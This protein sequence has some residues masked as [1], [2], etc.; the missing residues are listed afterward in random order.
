MAPLDAWWLLAAGAMVFGLGMGGVVPLHGAIVG[1]MI[2]V[3][4]LFNPLQPDGVI[5]AALI[6]ALFAPLLDRALGWS[7]QDE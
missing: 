3:I 1:T 2:V 5:F 4:R 6:G 7:K